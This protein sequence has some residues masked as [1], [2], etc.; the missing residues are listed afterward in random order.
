MCMLYNVV[1]M[2]GGGESGFFLLE[3]FSGNHAFAHKL[4]YSNFMLDP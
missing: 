1:R 3:F 4:T 2:G